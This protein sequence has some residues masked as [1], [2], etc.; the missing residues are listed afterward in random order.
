MLL[1][2]GDRVQNGWF[3]LRTLLAAGVTRNA[4]VWH[5]HPNVIAGWVRPPV[6]SYNQEGYTPDRG[7]V[8]VIEL[9]PLYEAL[10]SASVWKVTNE[11]S[12]AKKVYS[13]SI[14][15]W[16]KWLRYQYATFDFTPPDFPELRE[17]R[18]RSSGTK[19]S[20]S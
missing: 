14:K 19:M 15:P 18:G 12:G 13:A 6:V 3:V 17:R 9:D 10:Q 20:M 7:K 11:G 4:V 16:G 5:V 1:D 8:A 2:G